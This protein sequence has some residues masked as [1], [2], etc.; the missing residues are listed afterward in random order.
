MA[1][2][3]M[4]TARGAQRAYFAH[5][6]QLVDGEGGHVHASRVDS[7]VALRMLSRELG[8][9][10]DAMQEDPAQVSDGRTLTSPHDWR[11]RI[12]ARLANTRPRHAGT[13]STAK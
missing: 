6:L 3:E 2:A 13:S 12:E 9:D 5:Y 8:I 11:A 4:A 1:E 7:M 10:V